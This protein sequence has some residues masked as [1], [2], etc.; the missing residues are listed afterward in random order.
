[1][2]DN[3]LNPAGGAAHRQ[4]LLPESVCT[5]EAL[6][7]LEE[8]HIT[9]GGFRAKLDGAPPS[10]HKSFVAYFAFLT[11]TTGVETRSA[12]G[13][14]SRRVRGGATKLR[15]ADWRPLLDALRR[16]PVDPPVMGDTTL[17]E[18]SEMLW[19][20]HTRQD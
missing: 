1:M 7:W 6:A 5:G 12:L 14:L 4:P 17:I 3:E 9:I 15:A 16:E 18:L 8:G 2:I 10:L 20:A 11:E 13:E 19:R